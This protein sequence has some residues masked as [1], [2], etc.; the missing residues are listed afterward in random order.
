MFHYIDQFT[1]CFPNSSV[2][3]MP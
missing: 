2:H 1:L 3:F